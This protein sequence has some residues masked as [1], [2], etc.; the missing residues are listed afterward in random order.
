MECYTCRIKTSFRKAYGHF[1]S[2]KSYCEECWYK[3]MIK[4]AKDDLKYWER[5]LQCYKCK[6][7]HEVIKR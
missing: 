7:K 5:A 4:E 6:L 3:Q 2:S 1:F